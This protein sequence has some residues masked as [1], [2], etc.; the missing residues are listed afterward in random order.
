MKRKDGQQ[1]DI[2]TLILL[3]RIFENEKEKNFRNGRY[4]GG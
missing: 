3:G 2:F 1:H 4:R